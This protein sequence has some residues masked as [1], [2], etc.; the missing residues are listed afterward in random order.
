MS[1]RLGINCMKPISRTT[2]RG[3]FATLIVVSMLSLGYSY[4]TSASGTE[5][6]YANV[7][8]QQVD[9]RG[10]ITVISTDSNSWLG[11]ASKGPRSKAELVAF[12]PN[13]SVL[14]YNSSHT[15]YWDVD[16]IEK[17]NST[18]RSGSGE[19]VEYLYSDHMNA[20]QCPDF[21][22]KDY[23]Q[24]NEYANSVPYA[25][26]QEYTRSHSGDGACTRNGIVQTNLKTGETTEI[27]SEITPGKHSTRWHDGDRI[28]AT[29]YAVA[30]IFLDRTYIVNTETSNITW[31]WNA[32]SDYDPATT[33]REY[34][35]DWTHINDVEVLPD[36][37]IMADLRNHNSIVFL[38]PTKP[39][40]QALNEDW[41]IGQTDNHSILYEQHNPDYIP[42]SNG[43]PAVT[44]GD[45]E[46]NRVIEYQRSNGTW[47]RTWEWKDAHIQWPR[48]AD[49]L[50]NGNTLITD[51]NGDRVLEI[52]RWGEIV[53]AVDI[54]FP[55]E[56]ERL[57]GDESAGG[58]S[59]SAAGINSN[60]NGPIERVWLGIKDALA[61]PMF[62]ATQYIL[63]QWMGFLEFGA[64]VFGLIM[65]LSWGV[66]EAWW[67]STPLRERIIH[68]IRSP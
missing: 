1:V 10:N 29:H 25:Q 31:Q 51:S 14:Y 5:T 37:R 41:T 68:S 42:R 4:V 40:D 48:D 26:W 13:G 66:V 11:S 44:I 60:A 45:S 65:A 18:S 49:R 62:S 63:P 39:S 47:T 27:Y 9:Q 22:S 24:S 36:G 34:P 17:S 53:W 56:A 61:G 30:D 46:N 43:G 38:D 21:L 2:I 23:W 7:S 8:G 16:P 19:T 3:V 32:Q 52:N 12:A 67:L 55:Y 58:T 6:T 54:A 33:G 50:P 57:P 35:I 15:R 59:T 20:S 64:A 28:N